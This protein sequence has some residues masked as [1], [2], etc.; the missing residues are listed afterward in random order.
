MFKIKLDEIFE[1]ILKNNVFGTVVAHVK[2]VEFQK[3]ELPHCHALLILGDQWIPRIR[4][5]VNRV[6]S[7][8]IPDSVEK[9][10][11]REAVKKFMVHRNCGVHN[12]RAPC[13]RKGEC[14]KKFPKEAR[15]ETSLSFYGYPRWR[16]RLEFLAHVGDKSY[17]DEWVVP[18]NPYRTLNYGCHINVEIC[19]VISSVRYL[20]K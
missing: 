11:L 12:P 16:R 7:A 4:D 1:Y 18:Y 20:Y 2:V 10:E 14:S 15:N 8:E 19:G 3:R 6:C 9:P 17:T 13:M 5:H